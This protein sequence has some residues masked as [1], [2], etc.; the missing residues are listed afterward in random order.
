ME[1]EVARGRTI[2]DI[3]RDGAGLQRTL[4]DLQSAV[5]SDLPTEEVLF[6]DGSLPTSLAWYRAF[7]LDPNEILQRCFRR[8]YAAVFVLDPLPLTV[9]NIRFDDSQLVSFIHDWIVRDHRALGYDVI[10]VPV[11]A[12][13]ERLAFI[14]D[15]A[16][17][18]GPSEAIASGCNRDPGGARTRPAALSSTRSR[19]PHGDRF[20]SDH[21]AAEAVPVSG[22]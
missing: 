2:E 19:L 3:H 1:G 22:T 12:P 18:S 10:R 16:A 13:A 5:E 11:L 6:L 17:A 4:S 9:D 21:D 14:L 7:G 20:R 8:R 15:H